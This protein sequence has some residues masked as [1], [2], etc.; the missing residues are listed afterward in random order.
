M[1]IHHGWKKRFYKESKLG[2]RNKITYQ[3]SNLPVTEAA[4]HPMVPQSKADSARKIKACSETAHHVPITVRQRSASYEIV[5]SRKTGHSIPA[6]ERSL[7][8]A[9]IHR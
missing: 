2:A 7:I 4:D 6:T 9:E 3:T 5:H 8:Y 1:H